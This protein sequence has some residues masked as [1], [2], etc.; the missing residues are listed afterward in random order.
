MVVAEQ[1]TSGEA[2]TNARL[3][4]NPILGNRMVNKNSVKKPLTE[5]GLK[6]RVAKLEKKL[7]EAN[8]KIAG[9]SIMIERLSEA[10]GWT[11]DELEEFYDDCWADTRE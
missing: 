4:Q 3:G 5:K 2:R 6:G 1:V 7:A 11:Q 8:H 10:T 9:F